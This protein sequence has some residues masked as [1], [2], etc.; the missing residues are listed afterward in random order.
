[1]SDDDQKNRD[2]KY[3]ID[4]WKKIECINIFNREE[5]IKDPKWILYIQDYPKF[6]FGILEKDSKQHLNEIDGKLY[7]NNLT[8]NEI[9]EYLINYIILYENYIDVVEDFGLS[10]EYI[11][12]LKFEEL[13]ECLCVISQP[14]ITI[15]GKKHN[16]FNPYIYKYRTKH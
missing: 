13:I 11:K 4:N 14:N 2:Y 16:S 8:W 3:V 7:I 10:Y 9:I 6:I 1:M 12:S 15:V 5:K